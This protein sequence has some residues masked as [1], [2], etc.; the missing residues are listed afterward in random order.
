MVDWG[1]EGHP[2]GDD[3]VPLLPVELCIPYRKGHSANAHGMLGLLMIGMAIVLAYGVWQ[4]SLLQSLP[5]QLL[6]YGGDSLLFLYGAHVLYRGF[7]KLSRIARARTLSTAQLPQEAKHLGIPFALHRNQSSSPAVLLFIGVFIIALAVGGV[8]LVLLGEIR[9]LRILYLALLGVGIGVGTIRSAVFYPHSYRCFWLLV[10]PDGFVVL[11]G[12]ETGVV[13]RWE[14]IKIIHLQKSSNVP[15]MF[16]YTLRREDG[17]MFSFDHRLE[18]IENQ[19]GVR[20]QHMLCRLMLPQLLHRLHTGELVGFGSL[21]VSR[22]GLH[23]A[24]GFVSWQQVANITLDGDQMRLRKWGADYGASWSVPYSEIPNLAVF[25]ALSQLLLR[26]CANPGQS[27]WS[28]LYGRSSRLDPTAI[29]VHTSDFQT[30][31]QLTELP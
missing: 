16:S 31:S 10:Y 12:R 29:Q 20:V 5:K 17:E 18:F 6:F 4:S 9:D 3:W 8:M 23:H 19:F 24:E 2:Q 30:P 14:D 26:E 1:W 21:Q 22:E 11:H 13:W 25:F 7:R 28:A 15:V 27:A